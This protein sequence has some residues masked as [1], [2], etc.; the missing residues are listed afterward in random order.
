LTAALL[1][2]L[3]AALAPLPAAADATPRPAIVIERDGPCVLPAGEMRRRHPELLRHQR[4]LTVRAGVRGAR[5]SLN[6]CIDCHASR[7][8]GSVL[9]SDRNFC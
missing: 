1:A 4:E 6:V 9:G 2:V 7:V 8:N 3:A 5:V